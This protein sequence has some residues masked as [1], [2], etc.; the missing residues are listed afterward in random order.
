MQINPAIPVWTE[1]FK[2]WIKA[3]E[4]P[5]LQNALFPPQFVP[6]YS[7][8]GNSHLNSTA[9]K[10]GFIIGKNWK[11]FL[12]VI[13]LTIIITLIARSVNSKSY[14]PTFEETFSSAKTPEQLREELKLKEMQSPGQYIEGKISWRKNFIGETVLAGT[15]NNTATIANFKDPILLVTWISKTNT[16]MGTSR[17]PVYEYIG[18]GKTVS[19]KLKVFAPYKYQDVKAVI[20][21]ATPVD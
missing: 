7:G 21:S 12:G 3:R 14:S 16:E 20:E 17:H 9:E 1:G 19:Y 2:D 6:A 10:T 5:E 13:V 11:I 4:I 15:F 8:A 18:A